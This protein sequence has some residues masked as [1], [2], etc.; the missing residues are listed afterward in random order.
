MKFLFLI[1]LINVAQFRDYLVNNIESN[2]QNVYTE[3]ND[4]FIEISNRSNVEDIKIFI[5]M[6]I[7]P[8]HLS[9]N[10]TLKNIN[11]I[12]LTSNDNGKFKFYQNSSLKLENTS[13][14]LKTCEFDINFTENLLF[15][16]ETFFILEKNSSLILEVYTFFYHIK[17]LIF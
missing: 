8:Y 16:P 13:L 12:L 9:S 14:T 6:T 1:F 17:L 11:S 15:K 7:I 4:L 10:F 3:I 2:D 5:K